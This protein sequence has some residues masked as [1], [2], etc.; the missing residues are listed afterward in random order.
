M[1]SHRK[2][3][4]TDLDGTLLSHEKNGV[5]ISQKAINQIKDL[6][7]NTNYFSIA[8]GRHY[9]DVLN[10]LKKYNLKFNP[11]IF[12]IGINGNQI[13]SSKEKKLVY[14]NF[15]THKELEGFDV[16]ENYMNKNFQ[17]KLLFG[18][19]ANDEMFFIDNNSDVSRELIDDMRKYESNES[20][21]KYTIYP[22]LDDVK[23]IY[24]VC[25]YMKE[26]NVDIEAHIKK[27]KK[28]N[29]NLNYVCTGDH[30]FEIVNKGIS[31]Q[32]A[33]EFIEKNYY[34]TIKKENKIIFGD[35]GNDYEMLKNAGISITN[36]KAREQIKNIANIISES[37]ASDF[38]AEGILK[39]SNK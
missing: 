30:W 10:L 7:L 25:Y 17:Q 6:N 11:E 33:I 20:V 14:N 16:I 12:I 21:F 26:D 13:Y 22:S 1:I 36:Y 27:I 39:F 24:K 23:D 3:I 38:V 31:K 29:P 34:K 4:I 2:W 28:I 32:S 37:E 18:Y 19:N 35:S 9:K 15:L 8:T 5:F